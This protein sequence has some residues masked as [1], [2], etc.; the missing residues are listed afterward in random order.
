MN[1]QRLERLGFDLAGPGVACPASHFLIYERCSALTVAACS[2][3]R[4]Q[5]AIL[6]QPF[7]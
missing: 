7:P 6:E 5:G 4:R 1:P 2:S 3:L